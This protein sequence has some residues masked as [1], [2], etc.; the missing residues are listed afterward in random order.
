M[1]YYLT[2]FTAE[3]TQ[4]NAE[5]R[6]ERRAEEQKMRTMSPLTFSPSYLLFLRDSASSAVKR[7]DKLQNMSGPKM[8]LPNLR[9]WRFA[10]PVPAFYIPE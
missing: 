5:Q 9:R 2:F 10:R 6:E 4:K 7:S 1:P 8:L 3:R